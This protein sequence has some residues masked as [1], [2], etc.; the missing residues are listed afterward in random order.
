MEIESRKLSEIDAIKYL[1]VTIYDLI[2]MFNKKNNYPDIE[3][4]LWVLKIK[5]CEKEKLLNLF[6]SYDEIKMLQINPVGYAEMM[7]NKI[8]KEP[9]MVEFFNS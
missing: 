9:N 3:E 8:K 2:P 1:F 5:Y 6:I 4:I 7:C